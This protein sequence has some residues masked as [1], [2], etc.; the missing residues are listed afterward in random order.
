MIKGSLLKYIFHEHYLCYACGRVWGRVAT[1]VSEIDVFLLATTVTCNFFVAERN[2]WR[3]RQKESK[4]ERER[5]SDRMKERERERQ[6]ESD[7][8]YLD[9]EF[10]VHSYSTF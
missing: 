8:G 10:T 5:E 3:E 7:R 2:K 6:K 1:C 4:R 9:T